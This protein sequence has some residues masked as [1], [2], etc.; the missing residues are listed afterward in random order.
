[1][2]TAATGSLS[3]AWL[4]GVGGLKTNNICTEKNAGFFFNDDDDDD[5]KSLERGEHSG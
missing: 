2:T 3:V 4:N 1:M 5:I